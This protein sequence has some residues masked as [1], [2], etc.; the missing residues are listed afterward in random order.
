[1]RRP[2]CARHLARHFPRELTLPNL[3][4]AYLHSPARGEWHLGPLP[5]RGYALCIVLGII[6]AVWLTA[7]RYA[8]AGGLGGTI[9]DVA[10]WAVP[11]GLIGAAAGAAVHEGTRL[12]VSRP[13][14]WSAARAWDG[15]IGVPG[16]V[17]LGALG[18]WIACRRAGVRLG[19]VAG[20][21]APGLAFGAAIAYLGCWFSQQMYGRPSS[22]PWAVAIGPVHRVPG[23]ENFAT[24][25]PVFAY[26]A[27]WCAAAGGIVLWAAR[28]FALPGERAFALQL[29]LTSAGLC[30]A[31]CLLIAPAP[32]LAGM[33]ADQWAEL[34][35]VAGAVTALYWT[36]HRPGPDVIAP[37][38]ARP[39]PGPAVIGAS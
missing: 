24:F 13:D 30:A 6:V 25:E 14:L 16:A 11:F 36:R 2:G 26:E 18:A 38:P 28:R 5:V 8:K 4:V 22:L 35:T 29:A 12:F 15:A 7:S 27:M 20:A 23:Y 3:P 33:R 9:L 37:G 19:P 21:A 34:V 1:M 17:G 39:Q 31:E 10:A 32:H